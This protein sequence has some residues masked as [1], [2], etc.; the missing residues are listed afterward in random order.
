MDW[1]KRITK[2]LLRIALLSIA[3]CVAL[4][5]LDKVVRGVRWF[6]GIMAPLLIGGAIAFVLNV[7]MRAIEQ[8]L[9]RGRRLSK[10]R[11]PAAIILTLVAVTGVLT[12]AGVVVAPGIQVAVSSIAEQ[13]PA[14]FE[15]MKEEL[16][17]LQTYL[18][19]AAEMIL[20]MNIDWQSLSE[21]G[22]Q[23]AQLWGKGLLTSG[24]GLIGGI[25]SGVISF[26]IG[27]VFAFYILAQKE[28]LACQ[29]R[30]IT[31]ALLGERLGDK[32]LAVLRLAEKNFSNFLSVQCLEAVVLGMM[33]VI[34]MS[35]L[36]FPYALLIGVLIT[37]TALI[38]V[39]GA[40]IGCVVGTA[41]IAVN[42]PRQALWF[43]ALFF[44]LQQIEGKLIYPHVV[45]STVGLPSIWVL[46]AVTIGG[47]LFGM[48][49]MLVFIP[50]SSVLYA[51]IGDFVKTQISKKK[52]PEKKWKNNAEN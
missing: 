52:I 6:L 27:L 2:D 17:P 24:G 19:D 47:S 14:A 22:M 15:R 48:V 46:A 11:R 28:T 51:L 10:F 21:K 41:L 49:G 26:A 38:P 23:L 35:L 50:L 1:N 34:A 39:V 44:V 40:L 20:N 31:Y 25:V 5:R 7:P 29:S 16:F 9:P 12:L 36:H 4:L 42:D 8:G 45:G 13:A 18:P 43:I 37:V 32:T 3:F 33:F 30:Q